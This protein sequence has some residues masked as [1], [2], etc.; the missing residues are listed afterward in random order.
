MPTV[1]RCWWG[2][3]ACSILLECKEFE[4]RHKVTNTKFTRLVQS[5]RLN[6]IF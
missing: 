6:Q 3:P 4:N 5:C 2:S 1:R